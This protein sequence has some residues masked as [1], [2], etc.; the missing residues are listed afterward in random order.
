MT[1]RRGDRCAAPAAGRDALAPGAPDRRAPRRSRRSGRPA[2]SGGCRS[3]C[4]SRRRRWPQRVRAIAPPAHRSGCWPRSAP[5]P[6]SSWAE[7]W[8][9]AWPGRCR[10]R[11]SL[12]RVGSRARRGPRGRTRSLRRREPPDDER[13]RRRARPARGV[14]GSRTWPGTSRAATLRCRSR[15]ASTQRWRPMAWR[16]SSPPSAASPRRSVCYSTATCSMPPVAR[17]RPTAPTTAPRNVGAG[18]ST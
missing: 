5:T 16:S 4:S 13:V 8:P 12:G 18:T 1:S 11:C 6:P 10:S 17:S 14:R 3:R 7:A 9:N 15:C 2:R